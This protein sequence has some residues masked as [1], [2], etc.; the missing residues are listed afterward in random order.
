MKTAGWLMFG[1]ANVLAAHGF[2]AESKGTTAGAGPAL[3]AMASMRAAEPKLS[4]ETGVRSAVPA[5]PPAGSSAQVLQAPQ[6]V[7]SLGT[8]YPTEAEPARP[9]AL[10]SLETAAAGI[11][12]S[13]RS[14]DAGSV[15]ARVG[16][17][18]GEG[19]SVVGDDA[20]ELQA[21]RTYESNVQA[22]RS[23]DLSPEALDQIYASVRSLASRK[24]YWARVWNVAGTM[25]S[26]KGGGY[27][28]GQAL[29]AFEHAVK[30]EPSNAL[31]RF[32]LAL[33]RREMGEPLESQPDLYEAVR[34]GLP[35]LPFSAELKPV[36]LA[37]LEKNTLSH[38][39][40]QANAALYEM[41]N[42]GRIYPV[43]EADAP[44]STIIT[45]ED[46]APFAKTNDAL[47]SFWRAPTSGEREL[48]IA[49]K[50]KESERKYG[51]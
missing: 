26:R 15:A 35:D 20:P 37:F 12:D 30:L 4:L 16:S 46:V 2:A 41:Q 33:A 42:S 43:A 34:L 40:Y 44:Q 17:I 32:N 14:G 18:Y 51:R 49:L 9:T 23:R 3:T 11:E 1:I 22:L 39:D 7:V 36:L 28:P 50:M 45:P 25:F 10:A 29:D 8:S 31:F 47:Q 21:K 13:S 27:H 38:I 24:E 48:E 5:A 19:A 6:T